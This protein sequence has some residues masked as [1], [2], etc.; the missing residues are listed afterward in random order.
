MSI[1]NDNLKEIYPD[2][3]RVAMK[4]S[5]YDKE[6]AEDLVQKALLKALEKQSLFKGGNLTG[7]VVTIMRNI[8][9]DEYRKIKDKEFIDFNDEGLSFFSRT[10]YSCHSYTLQQWFENAAAL[11]LFLDWNGR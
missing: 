6:N 8:F 10:L 2:I 1:F 5:R 7:W 3:M 9:T 4:L 11:F